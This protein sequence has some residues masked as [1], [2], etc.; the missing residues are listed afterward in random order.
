[1]GKKEIEEALID[2]AELV[3]REGGMPELLI[4]SEENFV[5]IAIGFGYTKEEA[6]EILK[7]L[8]KDNVASRVG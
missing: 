8:E 3:N 1:M 4:M 2:A 5:D 6:L 7:N